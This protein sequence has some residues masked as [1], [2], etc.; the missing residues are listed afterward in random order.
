MPYSTG[1]LRRTVRTAAAREGEGCGCDDEGGE[2]RHARSEGDVGGARPEAM[3]ARWDRRGVMDSARLLLMGARPLA[4]L[5][6]RRYRSR[7]R[8]IVA[9]AGRHSLM[10]VDG[11]WASVL[12][13]ARKGRE[14]GAMEGSGTE[15]SHGAGVISAVNHGGGR[16][17]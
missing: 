3:A 14:G 10:I 12:R 5:E 2:R 7:W 4:I 6:G 15:A 8:R 9:R 17:V 11:A 13:A 16:L 1:L